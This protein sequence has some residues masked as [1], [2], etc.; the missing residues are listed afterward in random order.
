MWRGDK[1]FSYFHIIHRDVYD[2]IV[3][4]DILLFHTSNIKRVHC[5]KN[6]KFKRIF[7]VFVYTLPKN[8]NIGIFGK[9]CLCYAAWYNRLIVKFDLKV[10]KVA[11]SSQVYLWSLFFKIS[12]T[13]VMVM[14]VMPLFF[15]K[16]DRHASQVAFYLCLGCLFFI[17]GFC[18]KPS[19]CKLFKN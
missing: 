17:S 15:L 6:C 11:S 19:L 7:A 16:M 1:S 10:G 3:K 9:C 13:S 2:A 5:G 4:I 14:S 12:M 18:F 8:L